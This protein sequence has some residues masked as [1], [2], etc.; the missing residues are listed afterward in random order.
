MKKVL[1]L[2]SLL[3]VLGLAVADGTSYRYCRTECGPY[4]CQIWCW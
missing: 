3:V 2:A 4:G 1:A